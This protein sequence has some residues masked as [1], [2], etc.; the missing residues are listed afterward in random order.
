MAT[1]NRV[2][3]AVIAV[4]VLAV[5]AGAGGLYMQ[6]SRRAAGGPESPPP[7]A[8]MTP[9]NPAAMASAPG[10]EALPTVDVAAARM[11][12]RLKEKGGSGDEWALLGRTYVELKRYQDAVDA[13]ARALEKMPGNPMLQAEQADARKA[14]AGTPPAR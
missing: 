1:G 4:A 7:A 8:A 10:Q 6:L 9:P 14:A 11:A 5:L 12:Q 13:Y 2:M 3:Y